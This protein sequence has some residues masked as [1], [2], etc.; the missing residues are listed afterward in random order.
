M[1]RIVITL[2]IVILALVALTGARQA[3]KLAAAQKIERGKYIVQIAGCND[4]HTPL[5][6]GPR[7]PEPDMT[8]MLSGHPSQF[9]LPPAPEHKGLW[10]WTG[11]A[12]NTAFAGPWGIS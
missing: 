1:K 7:G 5:K 9:V 10:M 11:A 6:M 2:S 8:R 4:C 12:T 3:P